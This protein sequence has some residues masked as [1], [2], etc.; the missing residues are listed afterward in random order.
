MINEITTLFNKTDELEDY[1]NNFK[2]IQNR[3]ENKT[4]CQSFLKN[5]SNLEIILPKKISLAKINAT[6]NSRI[7]FQALVEFSMPTEETVEFAFS[8][9][10]IAIHS[11]KKTLTAGS[12]Q[13]VIMRNFEPLE[14]E[15]IEI[16]LTIKPKNRKTL[17]LQMVSLFVWGDLEKIE[18]VS[19]E[20]IE[21]ADK[22]VLSFIDNDSLY[23]KIA[24]KNKGEYSFMDFDYLMP[25][26]SHSF[27]YDSVLGALLL[28]RVDKAGNLFLSNYNDLNEKLLFS[29]VKKVS[30]CSNGQG[31]I[32]ATIIKDNDCYYFEIN[33]NGSVSSL[34]KLKVA[35]VKPTNCH[36][37]FNEYRGEFFILVADKNN[38]NYL[39]SEIKG[40]AFGVDNI[41][42]TYSI[43]VELAQG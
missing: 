18:N 10:D 13:I 1:L 35:S 41:S 40:T 36:C 42:A 20:A 43:F 5:F 14:S 27:V 33:A 6:K 25:A 38:S 28:F 2:K 7:F 11:D 3:T 30:V 16:F 4:T 12:N 31:R 19:Y 29:K 15:E 34:K 26:I 17:Y 39:V 32:L 23:V 8:V 9:N 24:D 37:Y 21:T 22:F